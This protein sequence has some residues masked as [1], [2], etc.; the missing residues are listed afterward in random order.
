MEWLIM[1]TGGG[2]LGALLVMQWYKVKRQRDRLN[3]AWYAE[4]SRWLVA[5]E[6]EEPYDPN[7][8]NIDLERDSSEDIRVK[9]ERLRR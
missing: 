4:V 1:S 7:G 2:V 9:L 6:Q 3:E 5:V 8:I